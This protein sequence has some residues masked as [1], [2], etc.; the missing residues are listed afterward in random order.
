MKVKGGWDS[1]CTV[2]R[3]GS[4]AHSAAEGRERLGRTTMVTE[5][6]Y[7]PMHKGVIIYINKYKWIWFIR[8]PISAIADYHERLRNVRAEAA[9]QVHHRP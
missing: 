8:R 6:L 5:V 2:G 4:T 9:T 1:V 7:T 3:L